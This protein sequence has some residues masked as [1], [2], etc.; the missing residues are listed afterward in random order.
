MITKA[1]LRKKADNKQCVNWHAIGKC[2]YAP[3]VPGTLYEYWSPMMVIETVKQSGESVIEGQKNAVQQCMG[4]GNAI[5][6]FEDSGSNKPSGDIFSR[7]A[8]STSHDDGTV[9]QM[10][11]VHVFPFSSFGGILSVLKDIVCESVP[12]VVAGTINYCSEKDALEWRKGTKELGSPVV[13]NILKFP[14][15]CS[16]SVPFPLLCAGK[17]GP[18]FPRIGFSL[19]ADDAVYSALSVVRAVS[20]SNIIQAGTAQHVVSVPI[21]IVPLTDLDKL[22][23]VYPSTVLLPSCIYIGADPRNP[24]AWPDHQISKDGNYVWAYWRRKTCCRPLL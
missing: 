21:A 23:L 3:E 18:I 6:F 19:Q 12:E 20:V 16:G 1:E 4:K 24:V 13:K 14:N 2:M 9:L 7:S 10:S 5:N 8:G 17:W 22:Q 11:E 15:L